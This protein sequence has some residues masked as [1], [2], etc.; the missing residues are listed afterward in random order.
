VV[1][2]NDELHAARWV[3]QVDATSVAAFS[4]TPCPI[5]GRV[6]ESRVEMLSAPP[7]RPPE[8]RGEPESDVALIKTYPGIDPVLL[9]AVVDA[10]ARGVVLE[11]TGM[12]SVPV[13]LFTTINE[14]TG[15]GIPV[16]IGSRCRTRTKPLDDMRFGAGL[17]AKMGAI[18]ARGLAPTKARIALMVALGAGG[19]EA[20]R[21]WF[22]RL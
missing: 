15:W 7:R 19:V 16:V 21:D 8:A 17:A 1:C 5:L 22:S 14:L 3:T 2:V 6:V 10:G 4:S 18:G 12:G 9:T 13:S 20:V 11:G